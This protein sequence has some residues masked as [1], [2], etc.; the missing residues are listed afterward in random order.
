[1]VKYR[2]CLYKLRENDTKRGAEVVE[3][4][5]LLQRILIH[6]KCLQLAV[7]TGF[8]QLR[9]QLRRALSWIALRRESVIAA[10]GTS[11]VT[12]HP[13]HLL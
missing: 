10:L 3:V 11:S 12:L 4:N 2:A 7:V 6:A 5:S 1:M 9:G 13:L 8:L